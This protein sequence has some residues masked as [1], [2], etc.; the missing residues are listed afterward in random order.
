MGWRQTFVS[1]VFGAMLSAGL[2]LVVNLFGTQRILSETSPY[3]SAFLPHIGI[4]LVLGAMVGMYNGLQ[5]A[6]KTRAN[7]IISDLD[8][9]VVAYNEYTKELANSS[10]ILYKL[11]SESQPA[12]R[13][14]TLGNKYSRWIAMKSDEGNT[15]FD[16]NSRAKATKYA[17]FFRVYGY[18]WGHWHVCRDRWQKSD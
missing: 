10:M 6:C 5:K 17:E 14:K 9:F 13:Y 2:G 11:I 3:L 15:F 7:V 12:F 18:F 8:S 4:G 1:V 16:A